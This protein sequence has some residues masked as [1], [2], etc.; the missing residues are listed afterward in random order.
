MRFMLKNAAI[1]GI[2]AAAEGIMAKST[3]LYDNAA[4]VL[5]S[6]TK[7]LY[8]YAERESLNKPCMAGD[9]LSRFDDRFYYK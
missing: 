5:A 4:W 1:W 9:M 2:C 3:N 8:N 6:Q 7:T